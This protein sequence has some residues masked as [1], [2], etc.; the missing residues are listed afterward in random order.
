MEESRG[1]GGGGRRWWQGSRTVQRKLKYNVGWTKLWPTSGGAL[2][3]S[4][5]IRT[6]HGLKLLHLYTQSQNV[7][8]L[9]RV[10]L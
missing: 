5:P 1:G 8:C 3:I 2:R 4:L 6:S 7:G 9:F 10:C